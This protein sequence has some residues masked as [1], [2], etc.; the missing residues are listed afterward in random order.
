MKRPG[1]FLAVVAILA[2]ALVL[3]RERYIVEGRLYQLEATRSGILLE[4]SP[5]WRGRPV[6]RVAKGTFRGRPATFYQYRSNG[7]GPF[8]SSDYLVVTDEHGLIVTCIPYI[9]E[10]RDEILRLLETADPVR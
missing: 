3:V 1:P 4:D 2:A 8:H 10:N 9:G 6:D 5:L 7:N